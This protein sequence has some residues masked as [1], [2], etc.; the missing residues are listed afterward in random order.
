MP[1][2]VI[3]SNYS[4]GLAAGFLGLVG[5]LGFG[6]DTGLD[7]SVAGDGFCAGRRMWLN[8]S[9]QMGSSSLSGDGG[10]GDGGLGLGMAR[11]LGR[12]LP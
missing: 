1:E 2:S 12:R 8:R 7:V 9:P 6:A 10:G 11:V 5:A 4:L 3:L